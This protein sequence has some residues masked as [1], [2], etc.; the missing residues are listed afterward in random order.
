MGLLSARRHLHHP[1]LRGARGLRFFIC[2]PRV[3]FIST[4]IPFSI[5][6]QA[7]ESTQHII[8]LVLS[9]VTVQQESGG[10]FQGQHGSGVPSLLLP[11]FTSFHTY[12]R[13]VDAWDDQWTGSNVL[14]GGR[15]PMVD[16][17]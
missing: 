5:A 4:A 6:L 7:S 15:Y 11:I 9:K 2:Y 8:L 13:P 17:H 10:G 14:Y 3:L 16:W 12:T 1:P